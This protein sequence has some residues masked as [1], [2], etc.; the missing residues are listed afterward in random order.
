MPMNIQDGIQE[1]GLSLA[2]EMLA[3]F[4]VYL[5]SL[6]RWNNAYN[7]TAIKTKQEMISKHLLDSLAVAP[8]I[9]GDVILDVGT[10]AGLPGIPLAIVFPEKKFILLDSNGKKTRFLQH[11]VS[12][13]SLKNVMVEQCRV[14]AFSSELKITSIVSRAFASLHDMLCQTAQLGNAKTHWLAMKGDISQQ[15]IEE[16]PNN[17][18]VM[19]V[20]NL[21]V[22][23]LAAHARHLVRLYSN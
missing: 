4:E 12:L 3:A 18:N 1:L 13:L 5:A 16:I 11:M 9:H 20:K 8:F 2:P 10:G 14:E 23:G 19:D 17:F 21:Q 6:A 7:L 15:E 22:P